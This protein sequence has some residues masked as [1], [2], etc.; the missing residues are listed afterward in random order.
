MYSG[1]TSVCDTQIAAAFW[2]PQASMSRMAAWPLV[3]PSPII[4]TRTEPRGFSFVEEASRPSEV[5]VSLVLRM[6]QNDTS[7]LDTQGMPPFQY[8]GTERLG[9]APTVTVNARPS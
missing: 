7:P 2:L 8:S 6:R 1:D 5:M 9:V 4:P 3:L